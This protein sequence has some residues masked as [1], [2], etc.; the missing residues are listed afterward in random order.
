MTQLEMD[1]LYDE[2]SALIDRTP[3]PERERALARLVI[4][5]AQ[6][7]GDYAKIKDAIQNA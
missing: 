5:L 4:T 7:L 6:Q 2:L 1:R 3:A